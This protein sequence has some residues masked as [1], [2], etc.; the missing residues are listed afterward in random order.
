MSYSIIREK[1]F[2]EN[3]ENQV[4]TIDNNYEKYKLRINQL[5]S[6]NDTNNLTKQLFWRPNVVLS[7]VN[8]DDPKPNYNPLL[9]SVG[10]RLTIKSKK[11][12]NFKFAM[13]FLNCL[14]HLSYILLCESK[15]K[16]KNVFLKKYFNW[17]KLSSSMLTHAHGFYGFADGSYFVKDGLVELIMKQEYF[18]GLSQVT[19]NLDKDSYQFE[20]KNTIFSCARNASYNYLSLLSKYYEKNKDWIKKCLENKKY[21]E[22]PL[23][24]VMI[25]APHIRDRKSKIETVRYYLKLSQQCNE[26][27]DFQTFE[28]IY[29]SCIAAFEKHNDDKQRIENILKQYKK[30]HYN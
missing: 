17:N 27:I 9:F 21:G 14:F 18:D 15:S 1:E 12:G 7:I 26:I 16:E 10:Y 13:F 3:V 6:N 5:I 25:R 24:C 23:V 22:H 8:T 20:L 19:T 4:Y 29:N 2:I 30:D 28:K 11:K